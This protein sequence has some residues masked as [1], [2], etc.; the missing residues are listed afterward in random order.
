MHLL[1]SFVNSV[2]IWIGDNRYEHIV[3]ALE[4][5]NVKDIKPVSIT[6]TP[7]S[8]LSPDEN[9]SRDFTNNIVYVGTSE[10]GSQ[11][12]IPVMVIK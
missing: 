1:N 12:N 10:A 3:Y 7:N 9:E 8:T 5:E 4:N 6:K 2:S 11:Y